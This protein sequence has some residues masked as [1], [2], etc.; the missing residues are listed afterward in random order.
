MADRYLIET[1]AV[2]GY[3]LEDGTGVL[4]LEQQA[5]VGGT[6]RKNYWGLP[7]SR[8]LWILGAIRWTS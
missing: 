7:L 4:I 2:D 1:S 6:A 5:A 8:L 3:L